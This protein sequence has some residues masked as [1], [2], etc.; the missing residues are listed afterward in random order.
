MIYYSEIRLIFSHLIWSTR[1]YT[2][3]SVRGTSSC[4][5]D[6]YVCCRSHVTKDSGSLNL[7]Y[8]Q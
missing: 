5:T 3:L 1:T 6:T 8:M 2:D 7:T 4:L